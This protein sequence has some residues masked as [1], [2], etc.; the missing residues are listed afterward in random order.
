MEKIFF[1]YEN[2]TKSG[3]S[4]NVNAIAKAK[5]LAKSGKVYSITTWEDL[6]NNGRILINAIF[7]AIDKCDIFAC[8]LT[9]LN[10]NVLFELGYAIASN[11]KLYLLINPKISDASE[12]YSK[13]DILKTIG[14]STFNNGQNIINN[15]YKLPETPKLLDDLSIK[16]KSSDRD[17][18]Y[19]QSSA[20]SQAE[21][22]TLSWLGNS[23][24]SLMYDDPE[25]IEY[26][27]F[28]WYI[29]SIQSVS[30]V[31]VHITDTAMAEANITNFKA[32]LFAGISCGM[33]KETILLGPKEYDPPIDYTD[34]MVQYIDSEDCIR[35][36]GFWLEKH[37]QKKSRIL[38]R[39]DRELNLLKLGLGYEI[40]ENEKDSLAKYFIETSAYS[41]AYEAQRVF[42][43]GRKGTGKTALYIILSEE[44]K[45]AN[46]THV[47]NLKPESTELLLNVEVTNLYVSFANKSSFFY[48]I[49]KFV[50]YS[51]TLLSVYNQLLLN[52]NHYMGESSIEKKIVDFCIENETLLDKHFMEIIRYIN[53]SQDG[54][55]LQVMHTNYIIPMTKLLREYLSSHKYY[56]I[57]VL[58][59][60]LDKTWDTKNDLSIQV[61]M[62][63]SLFEVTGV[64]ENDLCGNLKN[65][66]GLRVILFLRQDIFEY[67]LNNA[68][69]PD[70]LMLYKHDIDWSN[71]PYKLCQLI[72]ERFRYVLKYDPSYNIDS[73]W[74][75]YFNF[76]PKAKKSVFER[77]QE[78]CLPRPRDMLMFMRQMFESA[79]N[80]GHDKVQE[81]DFQYALKEYAEFLYQNLI[82]EMSAEFPNIRKVL[83]SLHEKY[84][85]R[86]EFERL[87][88]EL[89]RMPYGECRSVDDLVNA[90]ISNEYFVLT[91]MKTGEKY[92]ECTS[93]RKGLELTYKKILGFK[94]KP[95]VSSVYALLTSQYKGRIECRSVSRNNF[96]KQSIWKRIVRA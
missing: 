83:N 23:A 43:I 35:K 24:Y 67:V 68:R 88:N 74:A 37:V 21:L 93:A 82:A 44:F 8:D 15:L 2:A 73:V 94:I 6:E 34:I 32:S 79:V 70:K 77:L 55:P 72:E 27:T 18:F 62:L 14:Y 38:K 65:R 16:P 76:D 33:K 64:I 66:I 36:L 45:N 84:Y 25:E 48:S 54:N 22:D 49:W 89:E 85:D 39:E 4:V 95:K 29:D 71:F 61:D 51:K 42:F 87:V 96:R 3:S 20:N 56:E 90:L 80:N 53:E 26:R 75:E 17:I 7:D 91:N 10:H 41:K 12:R 52:A 60:N 11:K 47:V 13:I 50:I 1:A 30:S 58:A 40:A 59:D 31:I 19:I 92:H 78:T 81:I 46:Q 57:I 5:E 28:A 69:E 86:I 9:Y 63:L